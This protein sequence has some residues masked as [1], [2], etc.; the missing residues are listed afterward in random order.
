MPAHRA[1]L[2]QLLQQLDLKADDLLERTR[3]TGQDPVVPSRYRPAL[4]SATALAAQ[5]IGIAQI[6]RQRGG[7]DQ[8]IDI[9]LKRAAVPGLRTLAS[10][11]RDGHSLPL[12]RPASESKSFFETR[13]GRQMFLLRHAFYHLPFSRLLA[14]L[15]CSSATESL[16][17]AVAGRDAVEL[18]DAI[19]EAKAMG[20]IARTREEWLAHP[21]GRFLS[22]RTPVDIQRIGKSAPEPFKPGERPLAG[23]KVVDMGHVLAGPVVS[24]CLAEQGAKVLHVSAPHIPD[25]T[26][27]VIDTGFGKRTAY[28]DLRLAE[29]RQRLKQVVSQADIFVHSWRTGALDAFGFSAEELAAVRPGLIYVALSCYGSDGPWATR[30]GYDPFGQVVSGL[31]VGEG[32]PDA[33]RLASTFTLNDYLAGYLAAAGVTSALLK[34]ARDG[35]SYTVKV[36][37][38]G[39]SMWLQELGRLPQSQWPDGSHGVTELPPVAPEDIDVTQGPFG[40][41]EHARPII[42]YSGTPAYWTNAPMPA[43]ATALKWE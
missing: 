6:W 18:E 27:V 41:V 5:A 30:A 37:L 17:R 13:D 24:R 42:R 11:K 2:T 31:A 15:D 21:Q 29:D 22:S 3:L 8:D 20:A 43:G 1:A 7:G 12:Q 33:P 16:E 26:H 39:A 9:S 40:A 14:V 35:G 28:A 38:T 32:T 4:A 19:A 23:L 34:R 36:S 25:P 10:L